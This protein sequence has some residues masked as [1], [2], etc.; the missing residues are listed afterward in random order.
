M[1]K[2]VANLLDGKGRDVWSVE[3]DASVYEALEIMAAKGVGA[4]VVLEAGSLA[5]II[6]ERD[7]AR[8]VIL[9]DRASR[10]TPVRDIMTA[11]V[12]TVVPTDTVGQ[13]MDI[14]TERRI[15]HLPVLDESRLVGVVSIGDV[16]K[17]V[18]AEQEFLI[19]QLEQYITR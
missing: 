14:M 19:Q 15:R 2:T 5:G 4:L 17:G 10:D 6:S 8:K 12:V 16:V 3:A 18:I 9:M 13:C 11:E 1:Q 7:Y